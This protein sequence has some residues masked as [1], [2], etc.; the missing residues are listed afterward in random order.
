MVV[1]VVVLEPKPTLNTTNY[2]PTT[3]KRTKT[4]KLSHCALAST[5]FYLCQLSSAWLSLAQ[6]GLVHFSF[7]FGFSLIALARSCSRALLHLNRRRRV[8]A[9]RSHELIS[10]IEMKRNSFRRLEY[11][12]RV[13]R[14]I[15]SFLRSFVWH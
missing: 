4:N 5:Y 7:C 15:P 9:S 11:D 10:Q 8:S 6:L 1:V 14:A 12:S 2:Q 13:T 3:T